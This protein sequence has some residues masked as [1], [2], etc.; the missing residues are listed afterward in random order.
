MIEKLSN[1]R[2]TVNKRIRI[3]SCD[4]LFNCAHSMVEKG[5]KTLYVDT[6][7]K[8]EPLHM[9]LITDRQYMKSIVT[10]VMNQVLYEIDNFSL[11]KETKKLTN[12]TR[13]S[14]HSNSLSITPSIRSNWDR[15]KYEKLIKL[16]NYNVDLNVGNSTTV[17]PTHRIYRKFLVKSKTTNTSKTSTKLYGV[18]LPVN[19][20]DYW[21]HK[22]I[23][24]SITK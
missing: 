12:Y 15:T 23:Y 13:D 2:E 5:L 11:S 10:S 18:H 22:H 3:T 7:G 19:H 21:K 16:P 14:K 24:E 8:P 20:K 1:T 6:Y 4:I 9:P 17:N